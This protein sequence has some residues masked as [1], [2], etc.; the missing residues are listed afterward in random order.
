MDLQIYYNNLNTKLSFYPEQ[1]EFLIIFVFIFYVCEVKRIHDKAKKKSN[2][3][4][5]IIKNEDSY[6]D[7]I[8]K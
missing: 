5:K 4:G 8:E 6:D 1:I 3:R 7:L 2:K